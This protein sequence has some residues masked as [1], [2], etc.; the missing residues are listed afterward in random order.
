[1]VSVPTWLQLI[2]NLRLKVGPTLPFIVGAIRDPIGAAPDDRASG[3]KE[4]FELLRMMDEEAPDDCGIS[5]QYCSTVDAHV[6]TCV[7]KSG[8]TWDRS[9]FD[10]AHRDA[11]GAKLWECYGDVIANGHYSKNAT[12]HGFTEGELRTIRTVLGEDA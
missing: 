2:C 6:A 8:L 5:I 12:W 3:Q 9:G 11:L 10:V 7:T 1:M 4:L